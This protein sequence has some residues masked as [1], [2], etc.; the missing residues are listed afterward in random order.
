M[1]FLFFFSF[2]EGAFILRFFD[3]GTNRFQTRL[4]LGEGD[5]PGLI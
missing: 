1:A 2:Q 3:L 4:D 5:P